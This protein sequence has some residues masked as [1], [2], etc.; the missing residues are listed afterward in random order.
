MSSI[1]VD[2]SNRLA[3]PHHGPAT[4]QVIRQSADILRL[5]PALVELGR[6]CGHP[7]ALDDL[8]YFLSWL[9][10]RQKSPC[11]VALT[12]GSGSSDA[13][14]SA[15]AAVLL[16]EHRV[17][18]LGMRI[19]TSFDDT[20][21]RAL[22]PD[23]IDS[24]EFAKLTCRTL[25][26]HGA[27]CV[28]LTFRHNGAP[29]TEV[30]KGAGFALRW[31]TREREIPDYLPLKK[32]FDETLSIMGARTRNHLRY[33]RRRA[34]KDLGCE[35]VPEA[36]IS[37]EDFLELNRIS[38]YPSTDE[39]ARWKY[40]SFHELKDPVLCG[41]RDRDG[42]WL[43]LVGGLHAGRNMEMFWQ[44]NRNDMKP[45]SLGTVMRNYLMEHELQRGTRRLYFEG[46]TSHSMSHSFVK[47]KCT[48]LFILRD[49]LI[50]R[51]IPSLFKRHVPK[52]N[53][54]NEFL[55]DPNLEW[56]TTPRHA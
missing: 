38:S 50:A 8:Q 56:K 21:R 46:G 32:T 17:A 39:I 52:E 10:I 23:P 51:Q 42:R 16:Y 12:R 25:L 45:Y 15:H 13:N 11:M 2:L 49:N 9:N 29:L 24:A 3:F 7:G 1:A 14:V 20:G 5:Q 33:Y 53:P 27:Q 30:L 34:E 6:S 22:I 48:D 37:R 41:L 36:K 55:D 26:S 54:I 40:D 19:F 47:E 44:I 18:D 43:S 35:F 28:L 31:A 4:T